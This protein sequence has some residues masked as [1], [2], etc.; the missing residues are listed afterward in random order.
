MKIK[1]NFDQ[2]A[3]QLA[4]TVLTGLKPSTIYQRN[5]GASAFLKLLISV[6]VYEF[7]MLCLFS[8][9]LVNRNKKVFSYKFRPEDQWNASNMF[10][11]INR[12]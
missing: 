11:M 5:P 4:W 6:E 10:F 3:L 1:Y 9:M 2:N 12:G 7:S 8:F